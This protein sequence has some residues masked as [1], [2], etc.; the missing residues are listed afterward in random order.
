MPRHSVRVRHQPALVSLSLTPVFSPRPLK[1]VSA[2][3]VSLQHR[4]SGP[5]LRHC[6]PDNYHPFLTG[7][8]SRFPTFS[9][10][11]SQLPE[12]SCDSSSHPGPV[13]IVTADSM[14]QAGC[15]EQRETP[16]VWAE[17]PGVAREASPRCPGNGGEEAPETDQGRMDMQKDETEGLL[18]FQKGFL[19]P[20]SCR[21]YC[22][23]LP[24]IPWAWFCLPSA[25]CMVFLSSKR[26]I[27]PLSM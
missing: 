4:P 16:R 23:P 15:P 8:P 27:C 14:A 1:R 13:W 3:S 9:P 21:H 11:S 24:W 25:S 5:G 2:S 20:P 12:P 10:F 22:S 19:I 18:G 6:C 7:L 17:I 26:E